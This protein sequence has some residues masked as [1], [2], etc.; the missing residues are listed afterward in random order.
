MEP[1]LTPVL[2]LEPIMQST[3]Q[4]L[5]NRVLVKRFDP[6]SKTLGGI[7]LPTG[8]TE[9]RGIGVVIAMGDD[10]K[11]LP[12]VL[13]GTL[14]VFLPKH[15]GDVVA[16]EFIKDDGEH[17]VIREDYLVGYQPIEQPT[18]ADAPKDVDG[19]AIIPFPSGGTRH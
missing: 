11:E 7:I 16:N 12:R 8:S 17:I 18:A 4:P 3:F 10:C 14:V 15:G 2:F 5:G 9:R 6:E 19:Q 13:D 1:R